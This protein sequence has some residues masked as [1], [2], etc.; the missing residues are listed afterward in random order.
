[1]KWSDWAWE[2]ARPVYDD[3]LDLPFVKE[4][5][6]GTLSR[7]RFLFYLRQDS[8]YLENYTR[9]LAHIASRLPRTEQTL[10][11]L[12]FAHDGI[13]VERALHES[14]LKGQGHDNGALP[15]PTTLLYN[16]YERAK[17]LGPVEV[18]AACVLPCFWVYKRV[19]EEIIKKSAS[20]NPYSRWIETYADQTF[21]ESN[22]RAIEICDELAEAA[23]PEIR[24]EMTE[25]FVMATKME[26]MF[27]DS[28]Y[29]KETWKI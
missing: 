8:I 2:Q 7:D 4:L 13:L 3:I 14:Y 6:A 27:W 5:A 26:W 15:T 23:T 9:V 18:E 25:A 19:G 16:S 20:D 22:R 11:F 29:R 28:A 21:A 24:R 12:K 17:G 10:D 1:M